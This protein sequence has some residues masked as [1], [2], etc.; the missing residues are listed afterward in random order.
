[1][2]TNQMCTIGE[3]PAFPIYVITPFLRLSSRFC[4]VSHCFYVPIR[5]G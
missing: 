4:E 5:L 1:M 3:N 2:T